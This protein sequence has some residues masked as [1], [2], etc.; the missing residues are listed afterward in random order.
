MSKKPKNKHRDDYD[1]DDYGGHQRTSRKSK[2]KHE[3]ELLRDFTNST[4]KDS[5]ID[6]DDYMDY[7]EHGEY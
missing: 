7:F 1:D 5:E 6:Y 2:R 4:L 3:K